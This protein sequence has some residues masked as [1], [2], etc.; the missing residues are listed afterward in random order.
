MSIRN[1]IITW[2]TDDTCRIC[3]KFYD[4]DDVLI[5]PVT[6]QIIIYDSAGLARGT[7][8][9]LTMWP[10]SMGV[11]TYCHDWIIPVAGP[12]GDWKISWRAT[13][14]TAGGTYPMRERA[15]FKVGV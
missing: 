6:Q 10:G 7:Y 1:M 15:N 2:L 12:T 9:H 4:F 3:S 11:G 14:V 5:D 8:T 13:Y